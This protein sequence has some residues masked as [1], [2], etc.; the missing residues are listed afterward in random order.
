MFPQ[1]QF[2]VRADV[3]HR[4]LLIISFEYTD[5]PHF[6]R[7]WWIV[8]R[9]AEARDSVNVAEIL[10]SKGLTIHHKEIQLH[11]LYLR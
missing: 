2:S 4:I 5:S 7:V 8:S 11:L 3:E 1:K 6:A 9:N 10:F